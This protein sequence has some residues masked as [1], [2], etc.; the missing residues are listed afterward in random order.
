MGLGLALSGTCGTPALAAAYTPITIALRYLEFRNPKDGKTAT[1][2]PG[3]NAMVTKMNAI[4][5]QCGLGF[6]LEE[7]EAIDPQQYGARFHPTS[8]AELDRLRVA[9]EN[10]RYLTMIGTGSWNRKGDLGNSGSNCYSSFPADAADGIVCEARVATNATL[11]AHEVGH[12]FNLKHTND[13]NSDGV[14]DTNGSNSEHDLMNHLVASANTVLTP[15][16]CARAR[17]AVTEWRQSAVL[18]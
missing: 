8:Y 18:P 10:K 15:G 6:R 3:A 16:Q 1:D 4:W 17:A 7:Y 13:P 14:A 12:W 11:H 5:S 2:A 9:T